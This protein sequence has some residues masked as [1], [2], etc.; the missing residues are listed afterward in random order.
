MDMTK[1]K[2]TKTN[3]MEQL[4]SS[5]TFIVQLYLIFP[6]SIRHICSCFCSEFSC[7]CK[8]HLKA[9]ILDCYYR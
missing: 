4:T 1:K 5:F 8:N 2:T 7:E 9:P 6:D 3:N